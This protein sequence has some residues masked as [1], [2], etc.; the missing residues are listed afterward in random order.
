MR[1]Q[2]T[3]TRPEAIREM[4]S[5]YNNSLSLIDFLP[6]WEGRLYTTATT[7]FQILEEN[8]ISKATTLKITNRINATFKTTITPKKLGGFLEEGISL[9]NLAFET[10]DKYNKVLAP[11]D[12]VVKA[13]AMK[14]QPVEYT[15]ELLQDTAALSP[16]TAI[17]AGAS[18][19]PAMMDREFAEN[20]V[21]YA[22]QGITEIR[23]RAI[24]PKQ[25][26]G[27]GGNTAAAICKIPELGLCN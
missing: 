16:M 13:V 17:T 5:K 12:M 21:E 22:P 10:V 1:A 6:S 23:K 19:L 18:V 7:G 27:L 2:G 15:G 25:V 3:R 24:A 20:V 8:G 4:C 14:N 9:T 11:V 26:R